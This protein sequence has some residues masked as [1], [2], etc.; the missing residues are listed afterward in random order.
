MG[1]AA[2]M[3]AT[4]AQAGMVGYQEAAL[5]EPAEAIAA[6]HVVAA[7]APADHQGARVA[8]VAAAQVAP[9]VHQSAFSIRA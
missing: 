6:A 2:E 7:M 9:A 5:R 1:A 8:R 4:V 3:E